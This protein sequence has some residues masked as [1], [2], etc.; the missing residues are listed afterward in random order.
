MITL[1]LKGVKLTGFLLLLDL[2]LMIEDVVDVGRVIG[3]IQLVVI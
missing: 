2:E 1:G 3:I